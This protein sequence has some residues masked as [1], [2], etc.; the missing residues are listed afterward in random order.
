MQTL[1]WL[2]NK[3]LRHIYKK[4][5]FRFFEPS[6]FTKSANKSKKN[7]FIKKFNMGIIHADFK[8][9]EKVSKKCIQKKL[10]TKTWRNY[11]LFSLLLMFV[12]LV[13]LIT[14]FVHYFTTFSTVSKSAWSSAFFDIFFRFFQKKFCWVILALF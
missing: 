13:L 4:K 7:S 12:K 14:F 9:V 3:I 10:L 1:W 6:K 8:S 2:P 11:A 5:I